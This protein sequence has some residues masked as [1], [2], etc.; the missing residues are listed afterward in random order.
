[1]SCSWEYRIQDPGITET[2][3]YRVFESTGNIK[4]WKHSVLGISSTRNINLYEQCPGIIGHWE[5]EELG[6]Q[7]PGIKGH[8]EYKSLGTRSWDYRAL[9]ILIIGNN[10]LGLQGTG[11]INHLEN[12]LGL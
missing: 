6:T 5:Y 4:H 3:Q 2:Q 7:C 8:W 11:N 1:M 9:G 12:V 10:I